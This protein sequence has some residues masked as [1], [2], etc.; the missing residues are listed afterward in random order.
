MDASEI[1]GIPY[2]TI[3]LLIQFK[4][5]GKTP[6]QSRGDDPKENEPTGLGL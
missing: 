6:L 3:R 1:F 2:E 5:P 4:W